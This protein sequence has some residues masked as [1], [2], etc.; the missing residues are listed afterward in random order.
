LV[1]D[2][3]LGER[4]GPGAVIVKAITMTLADSVSGLTDKRSFGP[5]KT[6]IISHKRPFTQFPPGRYGWPCPTGVVR[7]LE[8]G[9]GPFDAFVEQDIVKGIIQGPG[10]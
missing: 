2:G 3:P 6:L 7:V 8:P 10:K 9:N 1:V 4:G 5:P